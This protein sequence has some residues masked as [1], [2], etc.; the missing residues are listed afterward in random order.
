MLLSISCPFLQRREDRGKGGGR[1]GEGHLGGEPRVLN[2][3]VPADDVP[4]AAEKVD[5]EGD[6]VEE[7]DEG[8]NGGG[9]DV[10][11]AG[12]AGEEVQLWT[13]EKEKV[14]GE[15]GARA[16]HCQAAMHTGPSMFHYS[17]PWNIKLNGKYKTIKL[18]FRNMSED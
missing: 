18:K 6:E 1:R 13:S 17:I 4:N 5:H 9:E 11:A 12:Q 16:C 2:A 15:E 10:S 7:H 3:A 14:G 8:G